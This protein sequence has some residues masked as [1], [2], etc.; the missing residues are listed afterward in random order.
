MSKKELK[1]LHEWFD[2]APATDESIS[3]Y[4]AHLFER[5]K[6]PKLITLVITAIRSASRFTDMPS[7]VGPITQRVLAG[8]R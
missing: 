6:A 7:P 2:G 8:V 5:G 4:I 1:A 3:R